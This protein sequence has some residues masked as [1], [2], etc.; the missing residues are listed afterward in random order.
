M[1]AQSDLDRLL[2]A[3]T[4]SDD[5]QSALLER[6]RGFASEHGQAS[7]EKSGGP[8]HFTASLIPFDEDLTRVLLVFHAKAQRWLQ[9][10]GHVEADDVSVEA[11]AR[12]EGREE[13]GVPIDGALVPAQLDAHELG[14]RFACHEHLDIRFATR[15]PSD[16]VPHVSDESEDVRWFPVDDPVVREE[17]GALVAAGLA[18][19]RSAGRAG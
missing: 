10:G 16:A 2:T 13:C 4:P 19:L 6:Y 14:G 8:V 9:P 5:Q 18:A 15:V 7:L 12:R 1:R 17:V 11:A 3:W